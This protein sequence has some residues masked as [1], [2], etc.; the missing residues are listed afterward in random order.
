MRRMLILAAAAATSAALVGSMTAV[1]SDPVVAS[2]GTLVRPHVHAVAPKPRAT[3]RREAAPAPVPQIAGLAGLCLDDAGGLAVPRGKVQ[4]WSCRKGQAQG[5]LSANGELIH[6]GMCANDSGW[7]GNYSHVIM[8]RCDGA[9]NERWTY[10]GGSYVLAAGGGRLCLDDPAYS[11][12]R[13]TQLIVY[14]C[15]GSANQRW[16]LPTISR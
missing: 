5:W 10:R 2:S 14:R 13:G 9:A 12:K 11:V 1:F 3:T 16:S 6:D 15:H 7:G 4:M 8:W